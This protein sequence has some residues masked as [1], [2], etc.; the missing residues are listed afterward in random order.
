M[1][2]TG[3]E[4]FCRVPF[5]LLGLPPQM[6]LSRIST[7]TV[8]WMSRIKYHNRRCRHTA[9][10][11]CWTLAGQFIPI[12]GRGTFSLAAADF[13]GDRIID[14]VAANSVS[15]NVTLVGGLS[16]G[17]NKSRSDETVAGISFLPPAV[18][19]AAA[20]AG[21]VVASDVNRD[22]RNDIIVVS[23]SATFDALTILFSAANF[24]TQ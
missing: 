12:G 13:N 4:H 18:L 17:K 14:I 7:K 11:R 16:S 21:R 22:K 1:Q 8:R 20:G 24:G 3:G 23:N 5:T 15:G 6:S 10:H 19:I 9:R 2:E